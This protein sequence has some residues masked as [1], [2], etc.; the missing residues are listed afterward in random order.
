MTVLG[1]G[2]LGASATV[3]TVSDFRQFGSA[4][5]FACW[6]GITPSQCSSGGKSRLGG[7]TKHGDPYLRMLLVQGAK[8]AILCSK[9]RDERVWLWAKQLRERAGWQKAAVA[10]AAKNA[11]IL[12]A[13]FTRD[14]DF[15]SNHLSLK[16]A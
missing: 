10:L 6:L 13:M 11:R 1:V 5:Q 12:W 4:A 3:A 2:P 9:P 8:A 16:P 7:I 14:E 15:K